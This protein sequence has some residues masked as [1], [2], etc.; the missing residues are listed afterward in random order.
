[1]KSVEPAEIAVS[2]LDPPDPTQEPRGTILVL[3]G[4]RAAGFW[5]LPIGTR[6][7]E[8]GYRVAL[9]DLRGH[10]GSTGASLTYGVRESQDLVQVIDELEAR[11]LVAGRLGVF[12]HSYGAATAIQLAAADPRITAIVAS[13]PFADL[14]DEVPHYVR[15]ALPGVGHLIS[16]DYLNA[17][18]DE[19][20]R[21]GQFDPDDASAE[22]A[23]TRTQAPILLVHGLDDRVIPAEHSQRIYAAAEQ[24]ARLVLLPGTGHF[25]AWFDA[26][27]EVAKESL[28]W[29]DEHLASPS[30]L[31]DGVVGA[32]ESR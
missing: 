5:M 12:G 14:R 24:P 15:L 8:A 22:A 10:G 27:G 21:I 32:K 18:L 25:G 1:V 31:S 9:V 20:G 29:L 17:A 3:H 28:A 7:S 26:Q 4:V 2:I 6:F 16:T 19:A 11:G 30:R 23:V 13:A